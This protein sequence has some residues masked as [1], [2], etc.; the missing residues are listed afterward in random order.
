MKKIEIFSICILTTFI[1]LVSCCSASKPFYTTAGKAEQAVALYI[2][3]G[4]G[5]NF[6]GYS[7][8]TPAVVDLA[9]TYL[10]EGEWTTAQSGAIWYVRWATGVE[11]SPTWEIDKNGKITPYDDAAKSFESQEFS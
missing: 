3:A 4:F 6:P 11:G 10:E 7:T 5:A 1:V 2:A 9:N 8:S